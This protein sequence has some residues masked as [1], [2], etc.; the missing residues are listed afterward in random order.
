MKAL[1]K[2]T[3]AE[4]IEELRHFREDECTEDAA[5]LSNLA[6][7]ASNEG[8]WDWDVKSDTMYFSP[9]NYT[10]LGYDPDEVEWTREDWRALIHPDDKESVHQ[11]VY[12]QAGKGAPFSVTFRVRNSRGEWQWV[13]VRGRAI[14]WNSDGSAL[15]MV[16]THVDIHKQTSMVETIREQNE[17]LTVLYELSMAVSRKHSLQVVIDT[18]LDK[19]K[20]ALLCDNVVLFLLD[21]DKIV[22]R[23]GRFNTSEFESLLNDQKMVGDC[24]CGEAVQQRRPVFSQSVVEDPRYKESECG[25]MGVRSFAA[26][27][28]LSGDAVLG[29]IGMGSVNG[30]N[31]E[32]RESFLS[33]AASVVANGVANALLHEDLDRHS[34]ELENLVHT[35]TRELSRL[36]NAMEFVSLSV[37]ITDVSGAIEYVNPFFCEQTGYTREEVIGENPRLFKSGVHDREFYAELW[38]RLLSGKTWRGEICNRKKDGTTYWE[39]ASI[40]PLKDADGN[41][42][43]FVSVKED[44]TERR[45]REHELLILSKAIRNAASSVIVTDVYGNIVYVNPSFTELTGYSFEDAVGHNP[46]ILRSG[47]HQKAF[48]RELWKTISAGKA[49]RGEI[50]NRRKDGTRFWMAARISPVFD[51]HGAITHYVGVQN[52]VTQTKDLEQLKDDVNRIMR[53]DLK[54]PLNGLIGFPELIEME[55]NLTED[56]LELTRAISH[57]ARKMLRM[58]DLSLDFFKMETGRYEYMPRRVDLMTCLHELAA[59]FS[60]RISAKQLD[61][62]FIFNGEPVTGDEKCNILS[63]ESL[64]YSMLSNLLSNAVEASPA[65]EEVVVN[66]DCGKGCLISIRNKGAVPVSVRK[67]FFRSTIRSARNPGQGWERIRPR[68]WR[69][70]WATPCEWRPRMRMTGRHFILKFRQPVVLAPTWKANDGTREDPCR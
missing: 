62:L 70:P 24:L 25:K 55:G 19:L 53:H 60:S 28:M 5:P 46:R 9:P 2:M 63:E 27:P 10:M 8:V 3:K 61:M 68:W 31:F 38:D 1:N 59:D 58:I 65:G 17:E 45:A 20:Q 40:S 56:Q 52:D 67:T 16:G 39:R 21:G 11:W 32:S 43:H 37:T 7:E 12:E 57:S 29:V 35:R 49:W 22:S 64:L 50:L 34:A 33:S 23:G 18:A 13:L 36:D 15:R 4:L 51:R 48:Y 6:V 30:M 47:L 54:T 69:T 42:T 41:V 66:L 44:I 14:E 26:L